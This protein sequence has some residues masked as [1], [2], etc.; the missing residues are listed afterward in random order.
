MGLTPV[1]EGVE[2]EKEEVR[3]AAAA[4]WDQHQCALVHSQHIVRQQLQYP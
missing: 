2:E 4:G 3:W 1:G